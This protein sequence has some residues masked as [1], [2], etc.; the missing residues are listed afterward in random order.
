MIGMGA[1]YT[2]SAVILPQLE[3]PDEAMHMDK[4]SGSWFGM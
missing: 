3:N 1:S 4:D 2:V